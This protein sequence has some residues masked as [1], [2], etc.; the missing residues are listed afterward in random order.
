M[1]ISLQS[2]FVICK[3]LKQSKLPKRKPKNASL[4]CILNILLPAV[5]SEQ[6]FLCRSLRPALTM[7]F[8]EVM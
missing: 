1:D 4:K 8:G 5:N 6:Q 2:V 7:R 3:S